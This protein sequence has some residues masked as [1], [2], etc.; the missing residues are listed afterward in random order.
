M[1]DGADLKSS[2]AANPMTATV[3]RPFFLDLHG[4]SQ[5][6][7]RIALVQVSCVS[8]HWLHLLLDAFQERQSMTPCLSCNLVLFMYVE[9]DRV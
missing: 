2:D 3:P 7:A 6:A 4:L 5:S 9:S 1:H 8:S